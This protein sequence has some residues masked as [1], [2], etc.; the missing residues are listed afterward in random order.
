MKNPLTPPHPPPKI[1]AT[2]YFIVLGLRTF[3]EY[4]EDLIKIWRIAGT[5]A[6]KKLKKIA[7]AKITNPKSTINPFNGHYLLSVLGDQVEATSP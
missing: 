7:I 2:E 5:K 4:L 6:K 3:K 1:Q